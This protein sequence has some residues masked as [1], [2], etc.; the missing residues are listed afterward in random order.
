MDHPT[1]FKQYENRLTIG[2]KM[3]CMN[4]D[5]VIVISD[6]WQK[7][8]NQISEVRMLV[9]KMIITSFSNC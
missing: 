5:I 3:Q 1:C 6:T 2:V 4:L 7:F 8:K 9:I